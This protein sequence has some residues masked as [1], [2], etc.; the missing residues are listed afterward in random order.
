LKSKKTLS[1]WLTNR[2]L[3]IIRNEENFAEKRTFSFTYAKII[4]FSFVILVLIFGIS[5]YLLNTILAY[6]LNPKYAR[7]EANNRIILLTEKV[8][9]LA[10]EVRRKDLYILNFRRMLTGGS[11]GSYDSAYTDKSRVQRE[12]DLDY[13]SPYDADLRKQIE[14]EANEPYATLPYNILEINKLKFI[15]PAQGVLKRKF[16]APKGNLG[17]DIEVKNKEIRAVANGSIVILTGN[18]EDGY[19]IAIQH[20]EGFI[21]HY[22]NNSKVLKQAGNFVK[23]GDV[24]S[25]IDKKL[26]PGKDLHFELWHNGNSVNPQNFINIK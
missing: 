16:D 15:S 21:S 6:W 11:A 17:I 12:P 9:S 7:L 23:A 5:F 25:E 24:I 4:V 2:F 22:F 19:I 13:L 8:D 3:L 10:L 1:N 18:K 14:S 20:E 26:K